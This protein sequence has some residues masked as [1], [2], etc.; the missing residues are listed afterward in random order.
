[1]SLMICIVSLLLIS[2]L[3]T[4]IK[5]DLDKG[6]K[7]L[8]SKSRLDPAKSAFA[9]PSLLETKVVGLVVLFVVF[10]YWWKD[11]MQSLLLQ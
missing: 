9:K 2:L 11:A 10:T 8:S 7:L 4:W 5:E 3:A 1:M 6:Q